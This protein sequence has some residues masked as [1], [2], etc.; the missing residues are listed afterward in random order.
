MQSLESLL[1][2]IPKVKIFQV[3][4]D[5]QFILFILFFAGVRTEQDLYAR[6]I[7][8]VTKQVGELSSCLPERNW[9]PGI[10]SKGFIDSTW[11]WIFLL[12]LISS[13]QPIS[14]EGQNKNP[15]MCR[16]L[17]THE[18]MCRWVSRRL[19]FVWMF[20]H[21]DEIQNI[22]WFH[23][24]CFFSASLKCVPGTTLEVQLLWKLEGG[25]NCKSSLS[26]SWLQWW[27]PAALYCNAECHWPAPVSSWS[28]PLILLW[29]F[30]ARTQLRAADTLYEGT[31]HPSLIGNVT[32]ALLFG[33]DIK[34]SCTFAAR[35]SL[36]LYRP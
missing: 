21:R 32:P 26:S 17:L 23:S 11:N 6:L 35:T 13:S 24:V 34:C 14:Y 2:F 20:S 31:S 9:T 10:V 36:K 27:P 30:A 19:M 4:D 3:T 33:Q 8:S 16:V 5:N 28:S 1:H 25:L 12:L 29:S 22:Y 15:E 18:V 7:D